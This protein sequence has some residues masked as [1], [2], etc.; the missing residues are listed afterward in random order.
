MIYY[1]GWKIYNDGK[2]SQK[3]V[4]EKFGVTMRC[5]WKQNLFTM[6]HL[7]ESAARYIYLTGWSS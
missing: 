3:W 1:L 6:I 5:M 2:G 7:R 4:A